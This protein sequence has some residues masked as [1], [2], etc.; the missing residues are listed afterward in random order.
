MTGYKELIER[1]YKEIFNNIKEVREC[2][3]QND[4]DKCR[5][6]HGD[7]CHLARSLVNAVEVK[8]FMAGDGIYVKGYKECFKC[9]SIEDDFDLYH[10]YLFTDYDGDRYYRCVRIYCS[11]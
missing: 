3:S 8:S 5:K 2:S 6:T 11:S 1:N 7:F 9:R 10:K 4:C